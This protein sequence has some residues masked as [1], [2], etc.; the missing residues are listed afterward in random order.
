ML[1]PRCGVQ[2]RWKKVLDTLQVL[3]IGGRCESAVAAGR[4]IARGD[5]VIGDGRVPRRSGPPGCRLR[6]AGGHGPTPRLWNAR[7]AITACV[8]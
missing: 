5:P 4:E 8:Q 6:P 2:Q 7:G 3:W 1:P